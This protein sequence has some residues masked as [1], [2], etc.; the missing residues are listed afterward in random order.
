MADAIGTVEP[1]KKVLGIADK[2]YNNRKSVEEEEKELDDLI[3]QQSEEVEAE[4]KQV[5]AEDVPDN[6]EEKTFKKRYGDLRRHSQQQQK[7][8]QEQL[9]SMQQQLDTATKNQIHLPKSEEE[10]ESWSQEYPDVAAI[11]ET[12]AIKKSKEQ[13]Q[14]LETR[15]TEIDNLQASANRDRAEVELLSIHPDFDSIRSSD[16]FHEWAEEQ[17]KWVQDALYE[18]ETDARSAARAIDLYKIDK[19]I[20]KEEKKSTSTIEK[21]AASL[22]ET[23]SPKNIPDVENNASAWRESDVEAMTADEYEEHSEAIMESLKT[24]TF[25]YDISGRNR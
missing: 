18:N 9:S 19:G 25:I 16:D 5:A 20:G 13:A 3:K 2:K 23:N 15:I 6:P 17:P 8:L 12:I 22:V 24:G 14:E 10:I 21:S 11:I 7:E 1:V 4:E